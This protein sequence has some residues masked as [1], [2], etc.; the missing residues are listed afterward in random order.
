MKPH[1]DPLCII[2]I[3]IYRHTTKLVFKLK[4]HLISVCFA[5]SS[6]QNMNFNAIIIVSLLICGLNGQANISISN[7]DRQCL[8]CLC[9]AATNCDL[10]RDCVAGYC[11]PYKISRLYWIDAGRVVLPED[12][13][14]RS[15]A[16]ED[17]TFSY[18]CAQ[19]LVTNYMSKYGRDCNGDG[20]TD[21]DDFV[22]INFNGGTHCDLPLDRNDFGKEWLQRY[23]IC[24]PKL[25]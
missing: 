5:S 17:C 10:G 18:G 9:Y 20:V 1:H 23:R 3:E 4:L 8:R 21:C 22:M 12:D 6:T 2:I 24:N 11:G 16:F 19:Q 7:L 13:I 14:Q 25:Y 15:G